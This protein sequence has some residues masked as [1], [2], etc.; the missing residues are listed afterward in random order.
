MFAEDFD[1]V[2]NLTGGDCPDASHGVV[3]ATSW[4]PVH[5]GSA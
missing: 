1:S 4:F 5:T 2:T 3:P